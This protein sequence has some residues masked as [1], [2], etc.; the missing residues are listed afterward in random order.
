MKRRIIVKLMLNLVEPK[1]K[2]TKKKRILRITF[3][4]EMLSL[5]LQTSSGTETSAYS[6][7]SLRKR[8][9][10]RDSLLEPPLS[11]M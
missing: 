3:V 8:V 9:K 10:P 4:A 2:I 6:L 1:F 11:T 7:L 5:T